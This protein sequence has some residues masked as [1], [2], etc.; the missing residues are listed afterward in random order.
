MMMKTEQ[1]RGKKARERIKIYKRMGL[2]AAGD[3]L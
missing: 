3:A 2:A 1:K